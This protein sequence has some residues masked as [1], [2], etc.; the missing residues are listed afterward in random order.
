MLDVMLVSIG[1]LL[2]F[3]KHLLTLPKFIIKHL[4]LVFLKPRFNKVLNKFIIYFA[5]LI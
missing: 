3:L 2:A 4:P 1:S 5:K